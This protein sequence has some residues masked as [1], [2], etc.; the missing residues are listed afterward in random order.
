[1]REALGRAA[2]AGTGRSS[3]PVADAVVSLFAAMPIPLSLW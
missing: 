2:A 3:K 1:M